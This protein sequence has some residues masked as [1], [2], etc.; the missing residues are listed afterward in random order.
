MRTN[1]SGLTALLIAPG[2][3]LAEQ[4]SAALL[5]TRAFQIIAEIK[6]YPA[7][8]ALEM[9]IRQLRPEIVLLDLATNID[10]AAELIRHIT[11]LPYPPHVVGLHTHNDSQAVLQSLR[12]GA[13]EFLHAPF[14]LE[15]QREAVTRLRRLRQP[16]PEFD[17]QPGKVMVFSSAKPGAGATT[18]AVQT[19]FLLQKSGKGRVL[20]A[21][22]DVMSGTV[23][24]YLKLNGAQSVLEAIEYAEQLTPSVWTEIVSTQAGMDILPAPDVPYTAMID[25]TRLHA[26]I[27]F[28]R[29]NYDWIVID[30]PVVFQRLS[31][32]AI[33]ESDH[34]FLISTSEL[35][36][37]HLARKAVNLLDHLGFPKDRFEIMLNRVNKRDELGAADMEKLFNCTVQSRIPNDYFSLHRAVTL[38]QSIDSSSD[39]GKAIGGV[40]TRLTTAESAEPKAK[41]VE[42][43]PV[44][45]RA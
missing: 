33:S 34:A 29:M 41:T 20:L 15:V 43:K 25:S 6:S 45:A 22:F 31:L 7:P 8:Q 21:D 37:L 4:F 12:V 9:R 24:F 35:P 1:A 11:S 2:R 39:L 5:H 14:D 32:M 10:A 23:S 40:V 44:L 16:E 30:L 42:G 3:E 13:C 18:I 27:E 19:A 36:S 28:A 26:V 38:G 17:A